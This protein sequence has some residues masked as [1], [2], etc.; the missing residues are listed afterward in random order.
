MQA[1]AGGA[2]FCH[3]PDRGDGT[4]EAPPIGPCNI[5]TRDLPMVIVDGLPSGTTIEIDTRLVTQSVD[6]VVPG[7]IHGGEK[8]F[9][10]EIVE[11][12][13]TGTG[14]LVGFN[15]MLNLPAFA[16]VDIGP[17]NPGD[18]VQAF[19]SDLIELDGAIFGDPDF[20]FLSLRVGQNFGL[21]P[22][23]G[24]TTLFDIGGGEFEVDSFFDVF[25]EIEFVGAPGGVLDGLFGTTQDFV[26][27]TAEPNWIPPVCGDGVVDPATETCDPPDGVTCDAS[28]QTIVP[29]SCGDGVCDPATE[30]QFTCSI[31]CGLPPT[32]PQVAGELLSL[33]T[34]ALMIA[35]LTSMSVWMIPTVLGLAGVG[36]YLVKF[37]KQ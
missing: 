12:Q 29:P 17:R 26:S 32:D 6:T 20:D 28:C 8:I 10:T 30:D 14:L 9:T 22:S 23:P 16:Q 37:R 35:G 13:L 33:N 5:F 4:V 36:V 3:A 15:R 24:F 21:P 1:Y 31:D 11:M 18:A 2:I 34:S 25:Y 27:M 7:G 19:P